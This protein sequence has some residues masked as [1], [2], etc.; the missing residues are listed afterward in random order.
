MEWTSER[1]EGGT[2]EGTR[3]PTPLREVDFE[4]TASTNS[5]TLARATQGTGAEGQIKASRILLAWLEA[6]S[7]RH[8]PL[9]ETV[10]LEGQADPAADADSVLGVAQRREQTRVV[11]LQPVGL[12]P[13]PQH[14]PAAPKDDLLVR[15]HPREAQ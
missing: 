6:S 11:A 3:T 4:S 14:L 5:A 13:Q 9:E 10:A 1:R 7:S 15:Q 12:V 2:K 8:P